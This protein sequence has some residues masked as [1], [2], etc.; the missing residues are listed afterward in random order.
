M[1]ADILDRSSFFGKKQPIERKGSRL[2]P[3]QAE[4]PESIF[5][6]KTWTRKVLLLRIGAKIALG[7]AAVLALTAGV[8]FVGWSGLTNFGSQVKATNDSNAVVR[9]LLETRTDEKNFQI[10][11][12]DKFIQA[13][14]ARI[15]RIH[16]LGLEL[17]AEVQ[18]AADKEM[19]D[20]LLAAVDAYHTAFTKYAELQN[21]KDQALAAMVEE[22]GSFQELAGQIEEDQKIAYQALQQRVD[23]LELTRDDRRVKSED[24]NRL[25]AMV[26]AVRREEKDFLLLNE[27][28]NAQSARKGVTQIL[29][30]SESLKKRFDN[31]GVQAQI[32]QVITVAKTYPCR[33]R[34]ADRGSGIG[35][36]FGGLGRLRP[37]GHDA[38]G[39]D[40]PGPHNNDSIQEHDCRRRCRPACRIPRRSPVGG[41]GFPV[42]GR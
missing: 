19:V 9:T 30:L 15:A 20:R 39:P 24:A 7:F 33:P 13:V 28:V 38:A 27:E 21:S 10:R 42:V 36:R 2:D 8:A 14:A 35:A 18:S 5:S 6:F 11:S 3:G 22:A 41:Q 26:G 34:K 12:D 23:K 31:A 16:E 4:D 32:D 17:K 1:R 25:L 40:R 37:L 29:E